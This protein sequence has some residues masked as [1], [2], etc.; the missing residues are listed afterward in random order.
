MY[1][2]A[3]KVYTCQ[4]AASGP[5]TFLNIFCKLLQQNEPSPAWQ[6]SWFQYQLT[7]M[8]SAC[9]VIDTECTGACSVINTTCTTKISNNFKKWKSCKTAMLCQ[10]NYKCMRY[11]WHTGH[12]V[13]LTHRACG[14][15]DT[16]CT[17]HAV[18]LTLQHNKFYRQLQKVESYAK[19]QCNAK[20]N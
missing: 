1:C 14:V 6:W 10:K 17:V 3:L 5:I 20:K 16:G 11:H 2:M 18:S 9:W 19:R 15:I 13:S 4:E 8:H 7:L 12:A